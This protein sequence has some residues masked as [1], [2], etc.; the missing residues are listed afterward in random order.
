VFVSMKISDITKVVGQKTQDMVWVMSVF[1]TVILT[2]GSII[3]AKSTAKVF[4]NG[5]MGTLM[6]V[7]GIRASG[8]VTASGTIRTKTVMLGNGIN[9]WRMA[10]AF[11][12]GKMAIVM[13]VN[14]DIHCVM[15]KA[16][17]SSEMEMC[18]WVSI[19]LERHR[20]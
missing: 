15:G 14:G 13:K 8:K 12:S 11:M 16:Q 3:T 18:T 19:S 4:T 2:M 17:T 10:M 7:N 6:M 5:I 1:L 20:A 9:L